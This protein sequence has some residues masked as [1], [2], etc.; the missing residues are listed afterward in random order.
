[1]H[2]F[3]VLPAERNIEEANNLAEVLKSIIE[4]DLFHL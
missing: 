2:G 4:S 1:M 3:F